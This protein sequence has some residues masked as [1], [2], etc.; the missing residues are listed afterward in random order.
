MHPELGA[1]VPNPESQPTLDPNQ[2]EKRRASDGDD[3]PNTCDELREVPQSNLQHHDVDIPQGGAAAADDWE[4]DVPNFD[5]ERLNHH[6]FVTIF[7]K[8][9]MDERLV[10]EAIARRHWL[11]RAYPRLFFSSLFQTI[12]LII[13]H[14][15]FELAV[16]A[17]VLCNSVLL[18]FEID[19]VVKH[20]GGLV[21]SLELLFASLYVVELAAKLIVWGWNEYWSFSKNRLDF[22]VVLVSTLLMIWTTAFQEDSRVVRYFLC[23]RLL[24]VIRLLSSVGRFQAILTTVLSLVPQ[25]STLFGMLWVLFYFYAALGMQFFGGKIYQGAPKLVNTTFA[26]NEYWSNNFNDFSSSF[27]TL[28]E[29]LVVNNWQVIMGGMVAVT[30]GWARWYFISFWLLAVVMVMNLLVAFILDAFFDKL[31]EEQEEVDTSQDD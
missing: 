13:N 5:K 29:L 20:T 11:E 30:S 26:A 22:V 12:R 27:I 19:R 17:A 25:F 18:W 14:R 1:R 4:G 7:W 24:R 10:D 9:E 6:T 21:S 23:M 16:D 8:F 2:P 15:F 31:E 3:S 28:F